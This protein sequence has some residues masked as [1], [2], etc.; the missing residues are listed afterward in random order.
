MPDRRH[1]EFLEN[2][3]F[4]KNY[5]REKYDDLKL[6]VDVSKVQAVLMEDG[7]HEVKEGTFAFGDLAYRRDG[8]EVESIPANTVA[9]WKEE[10]EGVGATMFC[11]PKAILALRCSPID[12]H[13]VD[14]LSA[15]KRSR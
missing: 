10:R 14:P 15:E 2:Q 8:K 11:H 3:E 1:Q 9:T 5:L 12:A 6:P 13:T 4:L 7:W